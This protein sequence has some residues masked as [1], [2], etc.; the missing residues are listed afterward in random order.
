MLKRKLPFA[1]ALAGVV[2][3][4][5]CGT[6]WGNSRIGDQAL[7]SVAAPVKV[8][9]LQ[10]A[11][12]LPMVER[13]VPEPVRVVVAQAISPRVETTYAQAPSLP[14]A[15]KEE[16]RFVTVRRVIPFKMS[17]DDLG[18]MGKRAVNEIAQIS[19]D[20]EHVYV[21]GR[22]DGSGDAAKNA[23]LAKARAVTVRSTLVS[24]GVV[25]RKLEASYCTACFVAT[26]ATEEGRR[27]NR[28]VDVDLV[29]PFAQAI[30]LLQSEYQIQAPSDASPTNK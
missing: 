2:F 23:G 17:T 20:A 19:K 26:N 27:R 15:L 14:V 25:R 30:K 8:V 28:R 16:H 10:K 4:S 18:P 1:I 22:S 5:G 3:T 9:P 12:N 11:P 24:A 7:V 29:L 13:V 6:W 21:R